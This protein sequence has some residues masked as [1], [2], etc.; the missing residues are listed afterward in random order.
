M[1]TINWALAVMF[2]LFAA[3]QYNDPDPIQW[4]ALYL[5]AMTVC[6]LAALGKN[7][8]YL[9]YIGLVISLLWAASI[10]PDFFT[11]LKE[12]TPTIAGTMKAENPHVELVR[13]FL[14]LL[15]AGVTFGW[16]AWEMRKNR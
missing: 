11:W 13:E 5:Q 16:Q 14:G 7:N 1:K 3:V 10:S 15:I 8:I 9:I 12:G 6:I 2:L 4:A